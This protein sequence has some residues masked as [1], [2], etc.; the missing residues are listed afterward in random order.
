MS[1]T[2]DVMLPLRL[3]CLDIDGTL[4]DTAHHLPPENRAAV[5]YAAEKGVCICLLS[6]RPPQAIAPIARALDVPGPVASFGGAL[7]QTGKQRIFDRRL[8]VEAV[9]AVL[10]LAPQDISLSLYRDTAWFVEREDRWNAAEGDIT[11]LRPAVVALEDTLSAGAPHKLLCM[12][13][14]AD[15]DRFYATLQKE[16][17]A[18]DLLRSKDE[19][20]EIMPRQAGK[21]EALL[22]VC[23]HLG[24]VSEQAMA[25][26][27]HDIDC[28]LLRA[29]GIGVAMGNGSL[30]ARQA[31]DWIAP[32]NDHAGVAAAVYHWMKEEDA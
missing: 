3:L 32:D 10:R 18:V 17:L 21:A 15:I 26:G 31:A 12:G 14:A 7:I 4:L 22:T 28:A 1:K 8:P 6:A 24:I 16:A 29:A 23:R 30:A 5:Q 2:V 11:G 25:I 13:E 9:Q 27:D 19:Y 20:L